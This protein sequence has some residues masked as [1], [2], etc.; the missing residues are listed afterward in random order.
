MSISS[1][2]LTLA[3]TPPPSAFFNNITYAGPVVP[4]L[5]T[6]LSSGA[7]ATTSFIYGSHTNSF[8]L[9]QG[10]VIELIV[11]N[12]DPGKHP[13]HLHG[14]A[15]QAVWRGAEDDG[16]FNDTVPVN[17]TD[18]PAIPMRRDTFMVNPNGNLVLRFRSDNPGVWLFHCH[19]EWHVDSGLTAT[20]IEAPLELQASL[21]IPQDH[22]DAC[23]I[24]GT[25]VKGNAA[26]N[27]VNLLDLT[28]ENSPPAPLPDG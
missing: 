26:G 18:F 8:V 21:V 14:H 6:V 25:P 28:G 1:N 2:P 19:I 11:N 24:D 9:D 15:F 27:T 12:N 23:N 20:M 4:T 5:Y 13:F 16:F 22:I 10:Q 17:E 3:N 7:M